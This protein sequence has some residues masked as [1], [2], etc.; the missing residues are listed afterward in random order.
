MPC[1]FCQDA[2]KGADLEGIVGRD[3]DM[4]LAV[5]RGR[6][7]KMASGLSGDLVAEYGESLGELVA[8]DVSGK[9][10]RHTAMTSSRT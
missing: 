4:V 7:A 5:D 6:K 10:G 3:G 9:P 8:G 1:D 2:G